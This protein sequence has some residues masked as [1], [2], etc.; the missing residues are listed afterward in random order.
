MGSW[1]ALRV[2]A[3]LSTSVLVLAAAAQPPRPQPPRSP[4]AAAQVDV[5]GNWVAQIT[6]DWR[7]RMITPPKGDYAS[8]P[9]NQLGRQ[10]ADRWDAAADEAAGEQCRAFG[11]GGLMRLPTRLEIDWQDDQTLR[12]ETDLG[13]QVRT[14]HFGATAPAAAEPT[15]QGRSV[16]EWLGIPQA[17]NP[18]G[19][20]VAPSQEAAAARGAAGAGAGPPSGGPPSAA[21]PV[22]R[23]S[24]KVVTT[25]LRPGYLRKNGVPYSDRAVV[26]EYYDRLT[27]FG[28]DYLQVVTVVTDPTYL[29]TPFVVSNQFKREP[30]GSKWNPTPCA[31]D[32][33]LGTFQAPSL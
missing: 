13:T 2:L 17:A 20:L 29:T 3:V 18:F 27:M 33:P 19:G 30:D 12:I 24:L 11:A 31:T 1:Q 6:E 23:G 4:R 26:T 16:A 5:T 15:W 32:P 25:N 8:V 10:T 9:L 22:A 14:L 28:N 7:W 21:P